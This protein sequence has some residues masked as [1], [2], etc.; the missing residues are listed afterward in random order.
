[1]NDDLDHVLS[2]MAFNN[3]NLR[4][5][6]EAGKIKEAQNYAAALVSGARHIQFQLSTM[7]AP[8]E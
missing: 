5:A 4:K 8:R 7:I 2:M 3:V 6:L 1:M